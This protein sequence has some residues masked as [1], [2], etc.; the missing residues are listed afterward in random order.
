MHLAILVSAP[1][2]LAELRTPAGDCPQSRGPNRDGKST[3]RT[4]P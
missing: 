3:E 2:A 4:I 1:A